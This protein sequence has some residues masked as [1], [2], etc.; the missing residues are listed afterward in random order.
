[1]GS[2]RHENAIKLNRRIL[3]ISFTLLCAQALFAQAE[4]ARPQRARGVPPA[5][6]AASVDR[7]GKL[8]STNCSFCHGKEANGGDGG[9]DL[10][11]SVLVNHDEN[12][13]EL[14][15]LLA[16]GRPDKGMP[17]FS[18]F[19]PEQVTDISNFLRARVRSIRYRQIYQLKE[20]EG[21]TKAGEAYFLK[22]C[23]ACHS[24]TGDL[25]HIATKTD[26]E[27][28]LRRMLYPAPRPG[29]DN[30]KTRKT[31]TVTLASGQSFSGTLRFLDE[32]SISLYDAAGEYHSWSR[33]T[34]KV[35]VQDPLAA[36]LD[37]LQHYTD[38][39]I[40]NLVVY[41]ETLK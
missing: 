5:P 28:L 35:V 27:A 31:T 33:D 4:L 13:N 21:D 1:M 39:E 6:D 12:G 41:L 19:N 36:H 34:V 2:G 18:K 16:T 29:S 9:P 25:N 22:H 8:F 15:P 38:A 37:L 23:V 40:H 17:A 14:G 11:R 26:P 24:T 3:F 7:G 32:F 30:P 10:I 20:F